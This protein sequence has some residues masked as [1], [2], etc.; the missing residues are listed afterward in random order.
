MTEKQDNFKREFLGHF[1]AVNTFFQETYLKKND[2][3]ILVVFASVLG[4]IHSIAKSEMAA[5]S[6][7]K[8]KDLERTLIYLTHSKIKQRLRL[9]ELAI[10]QED[11]L[12]KRI[13]I[14]FE[15]DTLRGYSN[16]NI[17]LPRELREIFERY[18]TLGY[19]MVK[20]HANSY[21]QKIEDNKHVPA[22]ASNIRLR[23]TP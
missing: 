14:S 11:E 16:L 6:S 4:E 3:P 1:D 2:W 20:D 19:A 13:K 10:P 18:R 15:P 5:N 8:A 12:I 9:W 21:A 7:T 17:I 22:P 23:T